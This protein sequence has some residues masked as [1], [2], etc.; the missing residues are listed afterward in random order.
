MGISLITLA[1]RSGFIDVFLRLTAW[2][3]GAFSRK[4]LEKW[5]QDYMN[6]SE[7]N[8]QGDDYDYLMFLGKVVAIGHHQR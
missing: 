4:Y 5:R 1:L 2:R 6:I 7:R 3:S 8:D